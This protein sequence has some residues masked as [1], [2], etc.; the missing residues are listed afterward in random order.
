[1]QARRSWF[2][3]VWWR[4]NA[5]LAGMDGGRRVLWLVGTFAAYRAG[6]VAAEQLHAPRV[7]SALSTAWLVFIGYTWIA[8]PVFRRMLDRELAG[9][10]I[11]AGF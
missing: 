3:G 7:A 6:V 5:L 4:V 11:R 9:V 10:R 8:L 2:L 1:V